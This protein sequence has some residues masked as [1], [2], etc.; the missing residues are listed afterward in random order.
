MEKR[1]IFEYGED[2]LAEDELESCYSGYHTRDN[3]WV[4]R[5]TF[6]PYECRRAEDGI[7]NQC[8]LDRVFCWYR[9]CSLRG[10]HGAQRTEE[11]DFESAQ[12]NCCGFDRGACCRLLMVARC[13]LLSYNIFLTV[14]LVTYAITV[15]NWGWQITNMLLPVAGICFIMAVFLRPK[16]EHAGMK[17][18][19][20]QFFFFATMSEIA[21][22]V[23]YFRGGYDGS[24]CFCMIRL[25]FLADCIKISIKVE[26]EGGTTT[27]GRV[28]QFPVQHCPSWRSGC[29]DSNYLFHTRVSIVLR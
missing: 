23:G 26:E 4:W 6:C 19:F 13:R 2:L 28:V 16:D 24:G 12:P 15:E 29:H 22:N 14:I 17:I 8:R 27:A 3:G 9:M 7:S 21:A 11:E 18:L 1:N 25:V 5:L 10:H 20:V